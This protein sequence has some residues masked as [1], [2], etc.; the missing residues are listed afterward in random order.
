MPMAAK[1]TTRTIPIMALRDKGRDSKILEPVLA[2]A[3]PLLNAPASLC[4]SG[5][6]FAAHFLSLRDRDTYA[7]DLAHR[8]RRR[9]LAAGPGQVLPTAFLAQILSA[10]RRCGPNR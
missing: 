4:A 1:I 6:G 10:P 3:E 5:P 8:R 7:Q 9:V 2:E